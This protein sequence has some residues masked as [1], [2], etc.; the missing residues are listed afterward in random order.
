MKKINWTK[1]LAVA[2]TVMMF[3]VNCYKSIDPGFLI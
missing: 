2:F 1:V 3:A